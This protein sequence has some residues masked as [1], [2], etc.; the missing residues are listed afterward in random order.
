MK[1]ILLSIVC[2]ITFCHAASAQSMA[3]GSF[4]YDRSTGWRTIAG[5]GSGIDVLNEMDAPP[6]LINFG[7]QHTSSSGF[8]YGFGLS[9]ML[10]DAKDWY[11]EARLMAHAGWCFPVGGGGN[12]FFFQAG[13]GLAWCDLIYIRDSELSS[14]VDFKLGMNFSLNNGL[15]LQL[16]TGVSGTYDWWVGIPINVAL[17]F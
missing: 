4:T 5:I 2:A 13:S 10:A 8:F 3:F 16:S 12:S 14:T 11:L 17:V 6:V 1:R 7:R 15:G 9:S